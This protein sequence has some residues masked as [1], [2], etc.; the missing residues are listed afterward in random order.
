MPVEDMVAEGPGTLAPAAAVTSKGGG[1][2]TKDGW[3]VVIQRKLP[4]GLAP[5]VRTQVAFAV[6][7][8]SQHEAGARKMRTGWIPL[9]VQ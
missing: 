7:E 6:W 3:S 5:R 4:A 9:V 2:R 1:Q 8:G